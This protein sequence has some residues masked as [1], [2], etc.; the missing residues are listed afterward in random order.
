YRDAAEQS[1]KEKSSLGQDAFLKLMTTQLSNQDPF[2]PMDNGDF[3][4]QMAQFGTVNGVN[5]LLASFNGLASN[6]QSG[7]ALQASTLIGRNVLVKHDE[8]YLTAG[9]TINAQVELGASSEQLSVNIYNASDSL[10][11]RLDM[12][13]QSRGVVP[14]HWDG[15][16]IGGLQAPQGRYRIEVEASRKGEA[17][18]VTPM[19]SAGV[20]SLTL[21]GI[22]KEMQVELEHLGQI[23]F[24]QVVKIL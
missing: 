24:S 18:S 15:T 4:A 8:A 17:E 22:G 1:V 21:G 10:V 13:A 16:T 9:G 12:G 7:Q 23:D 19:I 3:L 11:A 2:E 20:S 6:L 14:V 5:E